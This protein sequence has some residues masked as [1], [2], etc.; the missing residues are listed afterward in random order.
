VVERNSGWYET[1]KRKVPK[2]RMEI[3]K[4]AEKEFIEWM[5]SI[6]FVD[7]N[8]K[9]VPPKLTKDTSPDPEGDRS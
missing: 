8:G 2:A 3:D 7:K 1:P 6:K 4:K 5:K 9:V